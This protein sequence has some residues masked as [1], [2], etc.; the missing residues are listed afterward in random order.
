[1]SHEV[2]A[3]APTRLDPWDTTLSTE[4]RSAVK[5]KVG[6]K[7]V[8]KVPRREDVASACWHAWTV[9]GVLDVVDHLTVGTPIERGGAGGATAGSTVGP[10]RDH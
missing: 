5:P 7:I 9:V 2:N 10:A 1:V 8:V 4:R 3:A 6:D